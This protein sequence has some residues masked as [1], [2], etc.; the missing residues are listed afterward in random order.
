MRF[1]R[2]YNNV[3]SNAL[4]QNINIMNALEIDY[5][6]VGEGTRSGDAIALRFGDYENGKWKKQ[7]VFTIDGGN[8]DSGERLV[9]H[10][11]EVY[12]TDKVDRAI[13]THPD[14][15]HASGLQVVLENLNVGKI[16]MHCPWNHWPD[17]KDSIVD[18][19]I[20]KKSFGDT[21]KEAYQFAYGVEQIAKSKGIGI[22][23][24]H[25]GSAYSI[26]DKKILTV[27]SPGKDF[28]LDLIRQSGKTPEMT[29]NEILEKSFS[30][31]S[32]EKEEAYEDMTFETENLTEN[33]G[34]TSSENDMSLVLL[35][36]VAGRR[37]L[38]TGDAG[39][40]GMYKAIEYSVKNKISLK[41]LNVFHVP[42]HGSRRNLSKGIL[43]YISANAAYISC[44]KDGKPSHPSAIVTNALIRRGMKPYCTSGSQLYH[45]T[46]NLE[47]E[48]WSS[49][50]PIPFS[51]TVL[52][53]AE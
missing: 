53:D 16:W 26:N 44:S 50:T 17:L 45:H 5:L 15:D 6:P 11:I 3:I 21:L 38:F 40:M 32:R 49:A 10:I 43:E 13:L 31:I 23:S 18:G 4:N 33:D 7:T 12:K 37:I 22:F 34:T 35:L 25:Q 1:C 52:I 2:I 51:N 19:R 24:P 47:R 28:Y 46:S 30:S 42:H 41:D 27:L 14:S 29:A 20:T 9:K 39:T 8:K 48:G 36:E